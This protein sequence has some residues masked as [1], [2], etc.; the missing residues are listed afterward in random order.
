MKLLST[1]LLSFLIPALSFSQVSGQWSP[2]PNAPT[3]SSRINDGFFI[4]PSVGWVVSGAGLIYKTTN[5]GT[6]WTQQLNKTNSTHF[7]SVGFL[8]SLRGWVGCLGIGDVTHPEVTDTTILYRTTN[9]GTTWTPVNAISG[10]I[11]RGFC[12]MHVVNDSIICAVGRVRG[13]AYFYKTT[14]QGATWAIRNM[15]AFAAGLVDV[16]FVHPD[17]GFAVGLTNSLHDSSSGVIL[18]TTDG[19]LTWAKKFTTSRKGEWCWK[20][21]F[22]S[23]STA[24]VSLQRDVLSPIYILK[25]TD[26]GETWSEKLF[27]NSYYFMQGIGFITPVHGWLGGSGSLPA[28]ETTDGGESWHSLSIGIRLN[29][30][31]FF[32]DTLGYVMGATVS[33]YTASHTADVAERTEFP[34]TF[35]LD[36]NF[37]NPF[38]PETAISYQLPARPAGG[39]SVSHVNLKVYDLLG[40][41]VAV[42]VDGWMD[43]GRHEVHW[44][45][46][47]SAGGVYFYRLS[48]DNL[49]ETRRMVLIK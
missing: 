8:D 5:G 7:R 18:K 44:D 47:Q 13:P 38:N 25:S 40:R 6:S 15:S 43:T 14:D 17:T 37:P 27:S 42:L 19:G 9:G 12:G 26:G 32:G 35:E 48:V 30:F 45:G 41:E 24:Y 3:P 34:A 16:W 4:S 20:I 10:A 33:K 36:Q 46:S 2:L 23:R 39:S 28:Y 21:S 22:P 31:R 49:N 11:Q 29:R 1:T